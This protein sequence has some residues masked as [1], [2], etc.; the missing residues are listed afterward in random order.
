QQP[1]YLPQNNKVLYPFGYRISSDFVTTS[2]YFPDTSHFPLYKNYVWQ[3]AES[4]PHEDNK[5][6]ALQS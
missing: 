5:F 3:I 2:E 6:Y 4:P 1:S